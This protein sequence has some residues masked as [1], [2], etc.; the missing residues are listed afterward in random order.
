M[1]I[2]IGDRRNG[3]WRAEISLILGSD[4]RHPSLA[5]YITNAEQG[6]LEDWR[7]FH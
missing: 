6:R 3:Y 2:V 5:G 1:C 4:L 7:G